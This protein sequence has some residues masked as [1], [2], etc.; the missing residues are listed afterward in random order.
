MEK[1]SVA[2]SPSN[3]AIAGRYVLTPDVFNC[4]RRTAPGKGGE[5]QLT[6]AM[7]QMVKDRK[8]YGCRLQ[9][10]R[11]DI[12]NISGFIKTNLE[13]ALKRDDMAQDL[14][15]YLMQLAQNL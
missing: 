10:R 4:L 11:C 12:G 14:R 8:M 13:F 1:P 2:E 5:I 9:G 7:R 3:L 15:D 6:D